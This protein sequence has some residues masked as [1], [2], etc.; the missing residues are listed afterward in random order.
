MLGTIFYTVLWVLLN[1]LRAVGLLRWRVEGREYL[2]PSGGAVLVSNHVHWLDIPVHGTVLPYRGRPYW[3]AKAELLDSLFGRLLLRRHMIPIRRGQRDTAALDVAVAELRRGQRILIYPEG[4]RS[5]TGV[6]QKG[7]TGALAL[8]VQSG[9]PLVP[10]AI[11]GTE[12]G[13]K[14]V[15]RR[16]PILVR[17]GPPFLPPP[18]AASDDVS[19]RAMAR[20]TNDMM[21]HIAA[22]LPPEQRGPYATLDKVTS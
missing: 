11:T 10:M 18:D 1:G 22:L 16:Q 20:Y 7:K 15:L 8:A 4:H 3:I 14:G 19:L 5:R 12:H 6:L 21:G 9:A 17:F 2:P 13:L